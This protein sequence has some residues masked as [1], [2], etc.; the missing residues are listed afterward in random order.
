VTCGRP[1]AVDTLSL[2]AVQYP[3]S[4]RYLVSP[5]Q[6]R[7]LNSFVPVKRNCPQIHYMLCGVAG[8]NLAMPM[9]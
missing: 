9:I 3:A 5:G 4:T 2:F 1:I 7:P 8:L 6:E